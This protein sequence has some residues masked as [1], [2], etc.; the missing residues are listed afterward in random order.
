MFKL[1]NVYE[2]DETPKNFLVFETKK[3]AFD[4]LK[5]YYEEQTFTRDETFAEYL[6]EWKI[7]KI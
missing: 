4:F 2:Y 6:D 3:Q 5:K 1:I 7:A